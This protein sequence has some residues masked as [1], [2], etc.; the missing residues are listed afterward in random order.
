MARS[1]TWR[2]LATITAL[3]VACVASTATLAAPAHA[4]SPLPYDGC[5]YASQRTS[6]VGWADLDYRGC[7]PDGAATTADCKSLSAWRWTGRTWQAQ[8]LYD[9]YDGTQ[10]YAYPYAA[11]WTWIWTQR[12]GWLAIQSRLVIV[13]RSVGLAGTHTAAH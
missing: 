9:C 8:A 7:L 5:I 1:T 10:V 12:T 11:G 13:D 6:F 2:R 3:A 4:L